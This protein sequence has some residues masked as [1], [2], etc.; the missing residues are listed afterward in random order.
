MK[1]RIVVDAYAWVSYFEGGNGNVAKL[2][3]NNELHTSIFNVAEVASRVGRS[4][5]DSDGVVSAINQLAK[6]W[7]LDV[8]NIPRIGQLHAE[9]RKKVKDFGLGDCFVLE[10]AERL[11]AGIL[12]G[13]KHF[14]GLKN[15][16]FI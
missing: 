6:I 14:K 11:G 9:M 7:S 1:K 10:L 13:D 4:G 15:V 3:E 16:I 5:G 2:I 12:T 8:E